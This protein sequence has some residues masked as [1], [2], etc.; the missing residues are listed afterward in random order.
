MIHSHDL[1]LNLWAEAVNTAV[2]VLNRTGT[3][4]VADKTPFELWHE[5]SSIFDNLEVFGSVV[6]T[7]IPKQKRKKLDKKATRCILVGYAENSSG[8]RVFNPE[9]RSIE[10]A[11]DVIFEKVSVTFEN[12]FDC[13]DAQ[14]ELAERNQVNDSVKINNN[15][16]TNSV[17]NDE[18]RSFESASSRDT[19]NPFFGD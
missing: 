13:S 3:S 4:T 12:E 15:D 1:D 16:S 17:S 6:Y 7:H 5:K 18:D 10:V 8:F 9:K 14:S 19:E 11:R 2:Y